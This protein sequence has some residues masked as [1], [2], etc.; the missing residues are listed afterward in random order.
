MKSLYAVVAAALLIPSVGCQSMNG[1]GQRNMLASP[2]HV[3]QSQRAP[4]PTLF[5]SGPVQSQGLAS[6]VHVPETGLFQRCGYECGAGAGC[7]CDVGCGESCGAASCGGGACD[8]GGC[9][10]GRGCNGGCCGGGGCNNGCC[11]GNGLIN[12]AV[13]GMLDCAQ[14]DASYN[15]NQGPAV[16]QTAYPYYTT[17]GPRDFLMA[18]PPSIG[19]GAYSPNCPY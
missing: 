12:K 6:A 15:F 9:R 2:S 10:G 4:R 7:G 11:G 1:L 3:T 5:R 16:A 13:S 17:R 8:F 19:P 14:T 18:N